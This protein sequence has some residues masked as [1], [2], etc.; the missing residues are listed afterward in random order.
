MAGMC[1]CRGTP[2]RPPPF[3]VCPRHRSYRTLRTR[4][5]LRTIG[6]EGGGGGGG[7]GLCVELYC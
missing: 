6:E 1:L 5:Y 4:P 2:R 7:G 3:G